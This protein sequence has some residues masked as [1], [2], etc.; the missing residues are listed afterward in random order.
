MKKRILSVILCL[1][2]IFSSSMVFAATKPAQIKEDKTVKVYI[3]GVSMKIINVAITKDSTLMLST[4]FFT[5]LGVPS[6]G[7]SWDKTK[8]NLSVTKGNTK[9]KLGIDNA[10]A[11]LN[12]KKVT[13][14][15][16]PTMYKGK[17]YFPADFVAECF[18]KKFIGN[19]A[20]TS[21]Y[22]V[23][24]KADFSANQKLLKAI[25]TSMNSMS[26]FKVSEDVTFNMDGTGLVINMTA[27]SSTETDVTAKSEIGRAH[28]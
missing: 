28:V 24:S 3:D 10:T 12:G 15:I 5:S 22:F 19:A 17:A 20:D 18:D 16:K 6:K 2:L 25:L 8:K 11:S 4:E 1:A 26:R 7:L 14:P 27:K 9:I 13:L 23:K 21:T